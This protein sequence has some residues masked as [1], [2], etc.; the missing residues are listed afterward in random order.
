MKRLLFF[1]PI[2][3]L[4]L[5]SCVYNEVSDNT[6]IPKSVI[7]QLDNSNIDTVYVVK[8]N[9]D[10]YYFDSKKELLEQYNVSDDFVGI[11]GIIFLLLLFALFIL[12]IGLGAST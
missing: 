1:M 5:S 7:K 12:G 8:T 3:L 10:H 2:L 9:T 4:V 6:T 11:P